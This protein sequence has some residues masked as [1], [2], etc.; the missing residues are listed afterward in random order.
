[1]NLQIDFMFY[2]YYHCYRKDVKASKSKD[3]ILT[4]GGKSLEKE[5]REYSRAFAA[6]ITAVLY[7]M[8][9]AKNA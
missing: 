1:V 2:L 7:Q 4:K 3:R 6:P 5:T 9:K 8:Q